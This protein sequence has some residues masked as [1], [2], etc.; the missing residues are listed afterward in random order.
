MLQAFRDWLTKKIWKKPIYYKNIAIRF[1]EG[2]ENENSHDEEGKEDE[3]C[4]RIDFRENDV[5]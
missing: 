3:L 1:G 5:V 4:G 2:V